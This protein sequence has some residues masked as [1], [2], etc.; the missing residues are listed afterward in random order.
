LPDLAN[1]DSGGVRD[2]VDFRGLYASLLNQW[3]RIDPAPILGQRNTG[4]QLT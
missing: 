3:L 2:R 1:L 4:L